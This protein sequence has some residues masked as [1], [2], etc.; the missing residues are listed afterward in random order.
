MHFADSV[1]LR[2]VYDRVCEFE[3]RFG[4]MYW[5]PPQL[6]RDLAERDG[7]FGDLPD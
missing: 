4:P 2:E 3:K 6:L 1:G 7:R 5:K